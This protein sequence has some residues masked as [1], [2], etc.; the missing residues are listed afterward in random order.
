LISG[1]RNVAIELANEQSDQMKASY[2]KSVAA[3]KAL[4]PLHESLENGAP[5]N[6]DTVLS[7]TSQLQTIATSLQPAKAA[8]GK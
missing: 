3:L 4:V 6:L 1:L 2:D 7:I 8:K 5:L